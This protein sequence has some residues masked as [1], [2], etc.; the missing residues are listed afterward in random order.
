M[1]P[2]S[3]I[4]W[5]AVGRR[6]QV[7]RTGARARSPRRSARPGRCPVGRRPAHP[8]GGAA[9][10]RRARA[11]RSAGPARPGPG[12]PRRR[13]APARPT[14]PARPHHS[15]AATTTARPIRR[16]ADAVAA[17]RPGRGRGPSARPGGPLPPTTCA[18]PIQAPRTA[19]TGSGERPPRRRAC[20]VEARGFAARRSLAVACRR[21]RGPRATR[22]GRPGSSLSCPRGGRRTGRHD[23][24]V[25]RQSHL[26]HES[27]HVTRS[28]C[29]PAASRTVR[30]GLPRPAARSGRPC[31]VARR[32]S[33]L[34][35]P[36]AVRTPALSRRAA[37]M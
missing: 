32:Q 30:R 19:R 33:R 1:P 11:G 2:A 35:C 37:A 16:E 26:H 29:R 28:A 6:R 25:T 23:P 8:A 12:F 27:R 22:A 34:D 36:S 3:R 18:A 31:G 7:L 4:R 13:P 14:G 15:L 5:R 24:H 10:G 17:Q 9:A 20:R 21:G